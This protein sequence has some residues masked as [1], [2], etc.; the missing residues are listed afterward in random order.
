MAT[1]ALCQVEPAHRPRRGDGERKRRCPRAAPAYLVGVFRSPSFF[2][3]GALLAGCH[4]HPAPLQLPPAPPQVTYRPASAVTAGPASPSPKTVSPTPV[5]PTAV[6]PTPVTGATADTPIG[7]EVQIEAFALREPPPGPA[8]DAAAWTIRSDRGQPFRGASALPVGTRWSTGAALQT[9]LEGTKARTESDQQSLGWATA[10]VANGVLTEIAFA[11]PSQPRLLLGHD[12]GVVTVRIVVTSP[13]APAHQ[14]LQL[15]QTLG[16]G[17]GAMLYV[18][19]AKPGE[20]GQALLLRCGGAAPEDALAAAHAAAA[21]TPIVAQA[22]APWRLAL[23]AIGA[24][25]RRPALLALAS[26]AGRPRCIDVLLIADERGLIDITRA[27]AAVPHDAEDLSFRFELALLAGLLPRLERDDLPPAL[28]AS[29]RRQLGAACDD[30][31]EL[32]HMLATCASA[33]AFDAALRDENLAALDDRNGAVR[34]RAHDWLVMHGGSVTD[35]DPLAPARQRRAAL[36]RHAEAAAN[37]ANA[38][39]AEGAR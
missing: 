32:H 27:L 39:A 26:Q 11:E 24:H 28:Q 34:V 5:S 30:T 16:G 37:A 15:A 13:P 31:T 14:E 18:P 6:T 29:L 2:A 12:G 3:L 36:R 9:W 21:P 10:V 19:A 8:A 25:N 4:S 20:P 1:A 7:L 38:E 23:S 33:A 22:P 17:D 35:F